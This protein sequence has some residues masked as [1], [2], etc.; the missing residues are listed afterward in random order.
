MNNNRFGQS[1]IENYARNENICGPLFTEK[2]IEEIV[3]ASKD[4]EFFN[5]LVNSIAPDHP[6][7]EDIKSALA[8]QL[9]GG[10]T[11]KLDDGT[12]VLGNINILLF[13]DPGIN[14]YSIL[15]SMSRL[16][17]KGI[18]L[19]DLYEQKTIP[20]S[21]RMTNDGLGRPSI[22][23]GAITIADGGLVCYENLNRLCGFDRSA[24]YDT[25]NCGRNI[26]RTSQS[27]VSLPA[28]TSLLCSISPKSGK[29][30]SGI[31]ISEQTGLHQSPISL[32]NLVIPIRDTGRKGI[33][34]P[35]I[36]TED[37]IRKYVAYARSN[38]KPAYREQVLD[39]TV[40]EY[41]SLRKSRDY[42]DVR[43]VE[44]FVHLAEASAKLRLSDTVEE[45]DVMRSSAIIDR[46]L[47]RLDSLFHKS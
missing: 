12:S 34:S 35:S 42:M 46:C 3:R 1:A 29:I 44:L 13:A 10:N 24:L 8:L 33:H 38:C 40:N 26:I 36:Y 5:N 11:K 28:D 23:L 37:F 18:F 25:V 16:S 31:G 15:E 30:S 4:P 47:N 43:H 19:P 17:P 27:N 2:E 41:L 14:V 7:L 32:F 21:G 20:F 22:E 39:L 45:I 6:G 9:F